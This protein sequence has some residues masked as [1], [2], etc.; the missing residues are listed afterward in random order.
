[1]FFSEFSFSFQSIDVIRLRAWTTI[2]RVSI[3][4]ELLNMQSELAFVQTTIIGSP[5]FSINVPEGN[6]ESLS[7]TVDVVIV[8]V[9]DGIEE[10]FVEVV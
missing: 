6:G 5:K 9:V 4:P 1:L 10:P 2:R 3:T 7:S 8:E